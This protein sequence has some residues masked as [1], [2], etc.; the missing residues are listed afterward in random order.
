MF[1]YFTHYQAFINIDIYI[2]QQIENWHCGNIGNLV[3][4]IPSCRATPRATRAGSGAAT[5]AQAQNYAQTPKH[6]MR[7]VLRLRGC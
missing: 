5:A 6:A 1:S 2:C 4:D 3:T 7:V